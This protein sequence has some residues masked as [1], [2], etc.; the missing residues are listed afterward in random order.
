ML[1]VG[2]L[3]M[4]DVLPL[5]VFPEG[6]GMMFKQSP[7]LGSRVPRGIVCLAWMGINRSPLPRDNGNIP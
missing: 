5:W 7:P 4:L 2:I 1:V 3:W 6:G